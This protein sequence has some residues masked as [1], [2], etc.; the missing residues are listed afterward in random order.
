M[1]TF[2]SRIRYSE[3]DETG[4]LSLLGVINYLQDCSTFQS[5]DIGLGVEYLEEKKRAWLLSSW[6]IVI[7]RYP[8]LGERIK[9]GT[10]ATSSKG[11][12][13][14]RDFV[15]MDQDGNYLVRAESIWFFCD[16]EKMVPVRVMPEDVAAYGNEEALDLGKAPRKILIP[17]EYEEGIS[18]TIATH[19]LDTNHHVNNAQYV[20][21]AREAVPC[22]KMVKGIRADYKKA[23]VLGE[24][25]VPRVT[26]TGE[27]E[28]TV[29][30][31]DEA[32]EVRAVVWLQYGEHK[33]NKE[34][35]S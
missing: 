16:T 34:Y 14:Y 32:G 18:V 1:Y 22:T 20:D 8:V 5:E 21:I 30:L 27:D 7:D 31:A 13:G 28:W 6:R 10:W 26:K 15:I 35:G 3:T 23:A 4:A 25:L 12:Y 11:I 24:I 29:V 2:D 19:H 9:I 33:S 17:E